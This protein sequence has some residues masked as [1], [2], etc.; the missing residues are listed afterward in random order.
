MTATANQ[1]RRSQARTARR[2]SRRKTRTRERHAGHA[3]RRDGQEFADRRSALEPNVSGPGNR[4]HVARRATAPQPEQFERPRAAGQSAQ[5][6]YGFETL[7]STLTSSGFRRAY[8]GRRGAQLDELLRQGGAHRHR[9]HA[10]GSHRDHDVSTTTTVRCS[11]SRRPG[12]TSAAATTRAVRLA[13]SRRAIAYRRSPMAPT[14]MS[15]RPV[16]RMVG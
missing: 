14:D 12:R 6:P 10:D 9:S 16:I 11:T 3:R 13:V 7:T 15:R 2:R 4:C 8:R 5:D 1:P